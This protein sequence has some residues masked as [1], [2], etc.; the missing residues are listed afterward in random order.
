MSD[1]AREIA[2]A[3]AQDLFTNGQGERADRLVM[4]VDGTPKL[5]LGGWSMAAVIVRVE[6]ILRQRI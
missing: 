5:D 3:V 4:T 6:A 1:K 2:V